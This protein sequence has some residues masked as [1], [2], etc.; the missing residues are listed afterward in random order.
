M[1]KNGYSFTNGKYDP[2]KQIDVV[3]EQ[4]KSNAR[5]LASEEQ[6]LADMNARDD[7]LVEK[8][9]SE[10]ES[11]T[12]LTSKGADWLKQKN[13]KDKKDKLQSGAALAIKIPASKEDIQALVAQED[14]LHDAHLKISEIADRIEVETGSFE[15]A[16]EFRN[17]SGW[18]QYAYVKSSLQRAA[19]TYT[20][21]KNERRETI[22]LKDKK[23]NNVITYD[24]ANE[25]QRR[26]LDSKMRHEFSEQFIG[27][28]E[29]LL[30]ATVAPEVLKVDNAEI[31]EARKERNTNAKQFKKDKELRSIEELI[32]TD[33]EQSLNDVNKWL[34]RNE[35]TYG[36][37]GARLAF[38]T[39]VVDLVKSGK[40][41][42]V[43]AKALVEQKFFHDGDKKEVTLEKFKEFEG[44]ADEL[45]AANTEYRKTKL[46]DDKYEV[47]A[48]A[49]SLLEEINKSGTELSLE[50]KQKYLKQRKKDFPNVPL[51]EMEN[52]FLY[53]YRDDEVVRQELMQKV[54]SFKG[55]TEED[56][57]HASPK[58][59]KEMRDGGY[60][61]A[62]VEQQ[63]T[64]LN[65]VPQSEKKR[66]DDLVSQSAKSTGSLEA[67]NL[68][69]YA[70]MDASEDVY[71]KTYNDAIVAGVDP[72]TAHEQAYSAVVLKHTEAGGAWVDENSQ[73]QPTTRDQG[74]ERR[75]VNAKRNL[76]P[77]NA[78]YAT[79]L[80]E[81]PVEQKDELSRW[82]ANGGK[83]QVPYYYRAICKGTNILPRELAW[84]Q[85]KILGYEGQWD[86]TEALKEFKIPKSLVTL[87]LNNSPTKNGKKRFSHDVE[88]LTNDNNNEE[89]VHPY[90]ENEDID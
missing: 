39:R 38:R 14:G 59:R 76:D 33:S 84:K 36:R 53:G 27:V 18:E 45:K 25:A 13:E 66:L 60:L 16:E 47:E 61:V 3:P 74:Y 23:T 40:L 26:G 90:E 44:F 29:K 73:F 35:G 83:G 19:G 7:A 8:T 30:A 32:T 70:L 24:N 1:A 72:A 42:Y 75:L 67:K 69:Y 56:L 9:R 12:N 6:W 89:E 63:I 62:G 88:T 55:I 21:F 58:L 81:A 71:I 22:T 46:D 79:K 43:E 28:N 52:Q 86:E 57:K 4:E 65:Q 2:V 77:E 80:L 48:N 64:N 78:G 11:I 54:E 15:L 41:S 82:A 87:F 50:Q 85:A 37:S 51:N 10:W 17:L 68:Q 31:V 34:A 20:D 5:I 49:E